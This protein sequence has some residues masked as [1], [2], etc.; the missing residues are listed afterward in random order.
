MLRTTRPAC[1]WVP[2]CAHIS[3]KT[4]TDDGLA[5]STLGKRHLLGRNSVDPRPRLHPK[6]GQPSQVLQ[7]TGDRA[8]RVLSD[9]DSTLLDEIPDSAKPSLE[10]LFQAAKQRSNLVQLSVDEYFA[11]ISK[12][13]RAE[14]PEME[15]LM[16]LRKQAIETLDQIAKPI[17]KDLRTE[18]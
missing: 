11:E 3:T 5:L 6:T 1:V 7:F 14:D 16:K 12:K 18:A 2:W 10:R 15:S 17:R 9:L 8:R 13:L 4:T